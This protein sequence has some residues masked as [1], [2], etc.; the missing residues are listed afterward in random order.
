[1]PSKKGTSILPDLETQKR[2]AETTTAIESHL[3][4]FEDTLK[5][6]SDLRDTVREGFAAGI[7]V[8]S[9]FGGQGYPQT[10]RGPE[11]ITGEYPSKL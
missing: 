8:A 3:T 10:G 4:E 6:L 1:M 9:N 2:L 11:V 7:L 5:V